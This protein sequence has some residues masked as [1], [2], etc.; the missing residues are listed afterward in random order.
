VAT[1]RLRGELQWWTR[2]L[3]ARG[4]G[5]WE[6]HASASRTARLHAEELDMEGE[7]LLSHYTDILQEAMAAS[8]S[9]SPVRPQRRGIPEGCLEVDRKAVLDPG[10]SSKPNFPPN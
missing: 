7:R 6:S 5:A 9:R 8:P 3:L 10:R 1:E 2:F 4:M